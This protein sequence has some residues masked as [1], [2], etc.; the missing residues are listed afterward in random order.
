M[1]K[2]R[3]VITDILPLCDRKG[4]DKLLAT[5]LFFY[6]LDRQG[7][8]CGT[9]DVEGEIPFTDLV[10]I[11][12]QGVGRTTENTLIL[13]TADIDG[14]GVQELAGDVNDPGYP[15]ARA[16][17]ANGKRV[18]GYTRPQERYQGSA[19]THVV[20]GD[21]DGDGK[22]EVALGADA[23]LDQL[24]VFRTEEAPLFSKRV[25]GA[26]DALI[27]NDLDH[28][29]KPDIICG[30][31]LGQVQAFRGDGTRILL[32]DAGAGVRS[33]AVTSSGAATLWVGTID[34]RVLTM[35]PKG[36]ATSES[37]L[38]GDIDHIIPSADGKSV[39]VTSVDGKIAA[40]AAK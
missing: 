26:I 18:A 22:E 28:D 19:I 23:Y 15:R 24:A 13:G 33:I 40:F 21:F 3:S 7:K 37:Y 9:Y 32:A 4:G 16:W 14:D 1:G 2:Q 5:G 20:G 31:E 35:S 27:A 29:G 6:V 12:G 10:G 30:T 34:G 17:S 8:L 11:K 36:Q 25:G 38:G 39:L